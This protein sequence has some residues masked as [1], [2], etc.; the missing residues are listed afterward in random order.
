MNKNAM[1]NL[2]VSKQQSKLKLLII[3]ALLLLGL[4]VS[5]CVK[6]PV[7][8]E[9]AEIAAGGG[10]DSLE[11]KDTPTEPA[12]ETTADDI[13]E[14]VVSRTPVPTPMPNSINRGINE[15]TESTGLAG[16]AFLGLTIENWID[17]LISVLTIVIGYIWGPRLLGGL[18]SW[19]SKHTPIKLEKGFLAEITV[20][21]KRLVLL[22]FTSFSIL[23]LSFWSDGFRTLLNDVFFSLGLVFIAIIVFKL[24]DFTLRNYIKNIAQDEQDRLAPVLTFAKRFLNLIALVVFISITFSHFGININMIS[25][26]ILV[27]GVMFSLGAQD[28]I[29]DLIGSFI[30][31]LDQ[32]FRIGD[33]ILIKDLDAWGHV[34]AIGARTTRIKLRDNREVI[35]P[36]SEIVNS[37]VI[38]Y[39][40]P[41]TN[42]R[43]ETDI[44][45]GYRSDLNKTRQ[46]IKDALR[47]IEGV[48]PDQPV[49]VLFIGFG[50]S[51]RNIR[52]RWWIEGKDW[53]R[54]MQDK[55][56]SVIEVVLNEAGIDMPF[57][58]YAL[59]VK[60]EDQNIHQDK[61]DLDNKTK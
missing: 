58:T 9:V 7:A 11:S 24:I 5:A 46:V 14:A 12:G 35:I 17:I 20:E 36:N 33:A 56:N 54:D 51:S 19:I 57:N 23:R 27:I 8:L 41:D 31:L 28:T 55:V 21:L 3:L 38:N 45:V 1:S 32:P 49:D 52:V 18:L 42:Y 61:Q 34:L 29:S 6:Q 26:I 10:G 44:G 37:Q 40:Y 2:N 30:I 59:N 13:S 43:L 47:K 22:F 15:F 16:R 53:E 50:D 25:S 39:S 48:L 60:M 4:I